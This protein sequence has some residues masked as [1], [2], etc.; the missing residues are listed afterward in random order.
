ML[1]P[2]F[3]PYYTTALVGTVTL[4]GGGIIAGFGHK[5]NFW[6]G[7]AEFVSQEWE[8]SFAIS[9]SLA[10]LSFGVSQVAQAIKNA[11]PKTYNFQ[12]EIKLEEHFLKHNKDF[13]NMFKNSKEYLEA[14]NYVIKNGT[15]VTEM[16]GYVKFIGID[17]SAN[18]AFVG[19]TV[20][21]KN[22]TTFG[23]RSI[24]NLTK[25]TWIKL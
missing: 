17:G 20:N 6:S 5:H 3:V 19:M 7:F 18:Y 9:M 2:E 23:V 1:Y 24:K 22:I 25:I 13:N 10:M 11:S 4:F 16:N 21:G 8:P 14:A 15:Y 12:T